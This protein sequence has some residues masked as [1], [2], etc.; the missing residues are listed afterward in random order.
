M[1]TAPKS[2]TVLTSEEKKRRLQLALKDALSLA[3]L[4]RHRVFL[5]LY[6]GTGGVSASLRALGFGVITFDLDLAEA[7]GPTEAGGFRGRTNRTTCKHRVTIECVSEL[8]L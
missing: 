8:L 5:D 6:G 7:G 3:K 2:G 1:S 4:R